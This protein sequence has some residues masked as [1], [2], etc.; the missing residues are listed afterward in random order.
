MLIYAYVLRL[1]NLYNI[2]VKV[3]KHPNGLMMEGWVN[4]N[5]FQHFFSYIR[6]ITAV[7]NGTPFTTE[8]ISDSENR[9]QDR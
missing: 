1:T 6:T 9:S 5:S 4:L 3:S 2:G 8:T 7:S